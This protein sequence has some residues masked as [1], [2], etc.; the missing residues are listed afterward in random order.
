MKNFK[1]GFKESKEK[2]SFENIEYPLGEIIFE[3]V[4]FDNL[5]NINENE[6]YINYVN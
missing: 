4:S 5:K 3:K 6:E 1:P 2:P